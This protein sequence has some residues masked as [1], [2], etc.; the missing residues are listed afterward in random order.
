MH[1][2]MRKT[3][4]DSGVQEMLDKTN[5]SISLYS[6]RHW[7]AYLRLLNNVP[8]HILAKN[9]GTSVQKIES[10]YGHINTELHADLIT[11]GQGIFKRTE[12]SLE[13]LP[14]LE[15]SD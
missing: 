5:R 11:K 13:T 4:V 9:M 1:Q 10:T 3:L 6:N 8:I 2:R 12:T 14:T 15:D 7:Y